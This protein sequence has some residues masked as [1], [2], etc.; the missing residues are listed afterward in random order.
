MAGWAATA[1]GTFF[2]ADSEHTIRNRHQDSPQSDD[3]EDYSWLDN[4]KEH[5]LPAKAGTWREPQ[6]NPGR[7]E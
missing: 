4:A 6:E 3:K 1:K 2:H 7:R 5:D